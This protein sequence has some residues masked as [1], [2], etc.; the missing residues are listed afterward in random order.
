MSCQWSLTNTSAKWV[1]Q[2]S[3]SDQKELATSRLLDRKTMPPF[4]NITG[5]TH[6][7]SQEKKTYRDM[8]RSGKRKHFHFWV[9]SPFHMTCLKKNPLSSFQWSANNLLS[10]FFLLM[11][12]TCVCVCVFVLIQLPTCQPLTLFWECE[13]GEIMWRCTRSWAWTQRMSRLARRGR[14]LFVIASVY[15]SS[16]HHANLLTYIYVVAALSLKK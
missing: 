12:H 8:R 10:F 14:A 16:M 6:T 7:A 9:N 2:Q 4:T 15:L 1:V 13:S 5:I 11:P 3:V